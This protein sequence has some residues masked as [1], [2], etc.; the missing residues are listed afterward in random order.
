MSQEEVREI[1]D[2]FESGEFVDAKEMMSTFI[3]N[4]RDEYL[5]SRLDLSNPIHG[6][7]NNID[8]IDEPSDED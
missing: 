3:Q 1:L 2:K 7:I 4:K 8:D 6:E 5:Q